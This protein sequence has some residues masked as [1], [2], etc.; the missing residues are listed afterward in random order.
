MSKRKK[1]NVNKQI[2]KK[3]AQQMV[4][5]AFYKRNLDM[6]IERELEVEL[7]WWQKKLLRIVQKG[8]N[9]KCGK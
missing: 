6:F 2:S 3:E 9:K 5:V 1:Q 4:L 8:I 7:S